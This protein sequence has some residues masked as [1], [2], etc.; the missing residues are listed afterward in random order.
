M[1]DVALISGIKVFKTNFKPT[2][3]SHLMFKDRYFPEIKKV[4]Y[5]EINQAIFCTIFIRDVKSGDGDRVCLSSI[6]R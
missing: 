5:Q 1:K 6:S 3:A 2:E 4:T